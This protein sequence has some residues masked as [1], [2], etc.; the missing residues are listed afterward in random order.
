MRCQ[1]IDENIDVVEIF[2]VFFQPSM[3]H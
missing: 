1:N 2:D 3:F